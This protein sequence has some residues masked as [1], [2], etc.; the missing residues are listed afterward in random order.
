[1]LDQIHF[2]HLSLKLANHC[3]MQGFICCYFYVKIQNLQTEVIFLISSF[4]AYRLVL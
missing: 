3:H 4:K 2:S 1:M